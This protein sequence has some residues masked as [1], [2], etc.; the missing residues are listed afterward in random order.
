MVY[1]LA[2]CDQN[3][4]I[5]DIFKSKTVVI[6]SPTVSNNIMHSMAGFLHLVSS[7]KFKG[8]KATAFGCYGWSGESVKVINDILSK[9]GFEIIGDGFKNQWNPDNEAISQALEFGKLIADA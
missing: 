2:K 1:N 4:L 3:D 7:M 5:A 9:A 6:G 8:K